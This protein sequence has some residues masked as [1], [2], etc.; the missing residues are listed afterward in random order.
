LS[1]HNQKFAAVCC[2]KN[3]TSYHAYLF[4]LYDDAGEDG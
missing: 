4:N 2:R 3:A 1:T